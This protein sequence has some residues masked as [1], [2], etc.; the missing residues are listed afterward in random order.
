[1]QQVPIESSEQHLQASN[2]LGPQSHQ[3]GS[4][5]HDAGGSSSHPQPHELPQHEPRS[6]SPSS[7]A[8]TRRDSAEGVN[9]DH[10][11]EKLRGLS[12]GP[13]RKPRAAA[14][15]QRISDYENAL[16]PPTP[17]QAL[18]FKVVKRPGSHYDGP[19]IEDFP[20]GSY[21]PSNMPASC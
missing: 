16:T 6:V 13:R 18:G 5:H 7:V 17:K 4:L 15:G 3:Y 10:L 14:P 19:Q 8:D 1:M 11:D 21:K 20:N 9:A 2:P 12:L